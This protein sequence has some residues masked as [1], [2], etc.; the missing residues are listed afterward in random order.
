M[1]AST[2]AQDSNAQQQPETE[3]GFN[4]RYG[5]NQ[6]G[7]KEVNQSMEFSKMGTGFLSQS[8]AMGKGKGLISLAQ[9]SGSGN[10]L[11]EMVNEDD[12]MESFT[13]DNNN[14]LST[15]SSKNDESELVHKGSDDE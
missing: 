9:G 3:R 11:G 10:L 13:Q 5:Q 4:T 2:R 8:M 1:Y 14:L 12:A 6:A 15:P 7:V